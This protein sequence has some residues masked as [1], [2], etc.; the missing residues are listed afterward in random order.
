MNALLLILVL[1]LSGCVCKAWDLKLPFTKPEAPYTTWCIVKCDYWRT[2]ECTYTDCWNTH[3]PRPL[4]QDTPP[5][6]PR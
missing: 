1:A 6:K 5:E 2:P 3:E 4:G